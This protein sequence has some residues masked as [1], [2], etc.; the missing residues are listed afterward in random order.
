MS[1]IGTTSGPGASVGHVR[2]KGN[3]DEAGET[4]HE[5]P[6]KQGFTLVYFLFEH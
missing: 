3:Q 2:S 1:W 5:L 6:E 4:G